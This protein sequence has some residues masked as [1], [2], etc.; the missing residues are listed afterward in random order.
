MASIAAGFEATKIEA[1]FKPSQKKDERKENW[2]V[3]LLNL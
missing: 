3:S 2:P 1:C